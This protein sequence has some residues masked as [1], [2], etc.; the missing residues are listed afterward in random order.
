MSSSPLTSIVSPGGEPKETLVMYHISSALSGTP[1]SVSDCRTALSRFHHATSKLRCAHG[2]ARH[3]LSVC[4]AWWVPPVFVSCF[5]YH[6]TFPPQHSISIKYE[7]KVLPRQRVTCEVD[8]NYSRNV[9][10]LRSTNIYKYVSSPEN[11]STIMVPIWMKNK[12][13][14]KN[15]GHIQ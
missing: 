7:D 9:P 14:V 1:G 15:I 11:K 8:L 13:R 10:R 2:R 3:P 4:L 12:G 5:Q 6:S